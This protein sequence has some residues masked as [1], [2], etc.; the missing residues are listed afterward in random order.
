M[1]FEYPNG[2]ELKDVFDLIQHQCDEITLELTENLGLVVREMD[3][4]HVALV[5]LL[6]DRL[7]LEEASE[8][9][10]VMISLEKLT[11]VLNRVTKE[12]SLIFQSENGSLTVEFEGTDRKV[13]IPT[14]EPAEK[15]IPIPQLNFETEISINP[16]DFIQ[17]LK[18][19]DSLGVDLVV[20]DGTS[21]RVLI[22]GENSDGLSYEKTLKPISCL[23]RSPSKAMYSISYLKE[24]VS[25]KFDLVRFEWGTDIP[26]RISYK[27]GNR[28]V[29]QMYLAPRIEIE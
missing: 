9:G 11:K 3:P 14:M 18:D 2:P 13:K 10:R 1:R 20:F 16:K 25:P 24:M 12:D 6:I 22:K 29:L 27:L 4:A 17:V 15:E 5:D 19:L 26:L 28:S 21:E 7:D 23:V 8:P